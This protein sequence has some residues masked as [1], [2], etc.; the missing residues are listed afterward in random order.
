MSG[1][2]VSLNCPRSKT[3]VLDPQELERKQKAAQKAA[4]TWYSQVYHHAGL[5]A[6][7]SLSILRVTTEE[8]LG[9]NRSD[10]RPLFSGLVAVRHRQGWG[11]CWMS[12]SRAS[13]AGRWMRCRR[14]VEAKATALAVR[15]GGALRLD[16]G[17]AVRSVQHQITAE[18]GAQAKLVP[19]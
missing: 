5:Y 11:Q 15:K 6:D 14:K 18:P 3:M 1:C 17:A 7:S 10:W 9:M 16:P 8:L 12:V 19:S 4:D 13:K 2:W